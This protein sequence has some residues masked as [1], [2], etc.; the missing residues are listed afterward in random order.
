MSKPKKK[1]SAS[2]PAGKSSPPHRRRRWPWVGAV[3]LFGAVVFWLVFL[4]VS[5]AGIPA[6]DASHLDPAVAA[7][8]KE[9]SAAVRRAPR[10]GPAWGKLGMALQQ[11][12]FD[13]AAA[14]CFTQAARLDPKEP[15][16]PYLHGLLL[17][18]D[19]RDEAIA[20][21]QLAA[22]LA[23]A[24]PDAPH[25]RRAELFA[26]AGQMDDAER[27]YQ[28]ILRAAPNHVA[29]SL[30]L[31]RLTVARGQVK[32]SLRLLQTCWNDPHTRKDATLLFASL[33]QKSGD[34]AAAEEALRR[35][36]TLPS[37]VLWPDLFLEEA[38]QLRVGRPALIARVQQFLRNGLAD[39]AIKLL[40][41]GTRDDADSAELWLLLGRARL[42]RNE[43]A[44]AEQALRECVKLAPE[45]ANG[46]CQLGVALLC[47]EKYGEAIPHFQSAVAR[48]P[49]FSEAHF[50]LGFALARAGRAS[51]AFE[52]F[53]LAIRHSPN[54][55]DPYITLA[56]LLAQRG[57]KEEA[58]SLLQRALKINP[59]DERARALLARVQAR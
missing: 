6:V 46:H 28:I 45:S 56:D 12:E 38:R 24:Q 7:L 2:R 33:R 42:Q 34:T 14:R 41:Q 10:S 31:A 13:G 50:N 52:P 29:A 21:F 15:R 23:G 51:E 54:F 49:D 1:S 58:L 57:E 22:E 44:E 20:K 3:L 55:I 40:V 9:S 37:D 43:C 27:E 47:Q 25:L 53:R 17:S 16:W 36:A 4:Q 59:A 32:E 26:E 39:E 35:A 11:Y 18:H 8:L 30:G 48:K 5:R 19:H